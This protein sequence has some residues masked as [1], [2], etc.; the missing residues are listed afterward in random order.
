MLF[1]SKAGYDK[2]HH[3][4]THE[5]P[6]DEK[7]GYQPNA[8]WFVRR[9]ME[10]WAHYVKAFASIKEGDG[11][12][13]D[14]CLILGNSDVSEARVHSVEAMAAFTAGRMGGKIKT[15]LHVVG[16]GTPGTRLGLTAMKVMG[17]DVNSW[18]TQSNATQKEVGEILA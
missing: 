8:S 16:D 3:T 18:G 9:A 2:P 11:T 15:G 13:L 7:L 6:K 17:L 5:E 12:V 1:R 10:S 14:N 4:C